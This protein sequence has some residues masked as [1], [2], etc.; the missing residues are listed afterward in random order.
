MQPADLGL[1]GSMKRS[2]YKSVREYTQQ[3]PN[4]DITKKNFCSVLKSTWEDV[5]RP[6]ILT[7]AFRK[8]G[9][10]LLDK[11]EVSKGLL[12]PPNQFVDAN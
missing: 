6:S 7:D 2:W 9:I 12:G 8:S 5:M 11:G 3:N 4:T 1:F 10:Y